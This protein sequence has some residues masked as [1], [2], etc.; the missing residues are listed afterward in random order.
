M[1]AQAKKENAAAAGA[2]CANAERKTEEFEIMC[3]GNIM[4]DSVVTANEAGGW[5]R[6]R[7]VLCTASEDEDHI[8]FNN[9]LVEHDT[10]DGLDENKKSSGIKWNLKHIPQKPR[11]LSPWRLQERQV[12]N[13]PI[14][15]QPT[16]KQIASRVKVTTHG[17]STRS[18]RQVLLCYMSA[19]T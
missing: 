17:T 9:D 18:L 2:N 6:G 13:I 10:D 5:H 7:P 11:R 16:Y 1:K 12:K 15:S 3:K 14:E 8:A 19:T 4:S